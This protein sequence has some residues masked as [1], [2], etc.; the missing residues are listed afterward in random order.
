MQ[1]NKYDYEAEIDIVDIA[2]YIAYH[3]RKI[4]IMAFICAVVFFVCRFIII[5]IPDKDSGISEVQRIER[6]YE[7][8]LQEYHD[9][10]S[11]IE[12]TKI[13]NKARLDDI[14]RYI[15]KSVLM[16]ID[17][18][19]E[20]TGTKRY[21]VQLAEAVLNTAMTT[22]TY[23]P[24]QYVQNAYLVRFKE[25][26]DESEMQALFGVS[27]LQFINEVVGLTLNVSAGTMTIW[28]RGASE[29]Y[30]TRVIDYFASRLEK[31]YAEVLKIVEH[32]LVPYEKETIC[33][34]NKELYDKRASYEKEIIDIGLTDVETERKINYLRDN[35]EPEPEGKGRVKFAVIGFFVGV[36]IA[37]GRYAFKYIA[38]GKLHNADEISLRYGLPIYGEIMKSF[39]KIQGKGIDGIIDRIRL[40][41]AIPDEIVYDSIAMLIKESSYNNILLTGTISN[42]VLNQFVELL[43]KKLNSEQ[44]LY[45]RADILNDPS[46][47]TEA[48]RMQ[49]VIIVEKKEMSKKADI[50]RMAEML[51]ISG[52]EVIGAVV[53]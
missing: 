41:K 8:V 11:A 36:F 30:V 24:M 2:T 29:N 17:W 9:N 1:Y 37:C 13:V 18:L 53:L 38:G 27:E 16:K 45:V 32:S 20:W 49:A 15:D 5:I 46:A 14:N 12:S 43:K 33:R 44:K 47:I 4:L 34:Y 48:K 23:N 7:L 39:A 28:A 31:S 26:L 6:D 22:E 21:Q 35:G 3:W 25:N 42:G 51:S 40:R 10:I 19:N 50:E 52:A